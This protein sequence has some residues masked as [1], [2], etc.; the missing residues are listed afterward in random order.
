ADRDSLSARRLRPNDKRGPGPGSCDHRPERGDEGGGRRQTPHSFFSVTFTFA[1]SRPAFSA[2]RMRTVLGF[3]PGAAS[4]R[5]WTPGPLKR[6]GDSEEKEDAFP[7][8]LSP[9][10]TVASGGSA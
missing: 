6:S 2:T 7:S 10:D 4:D 5:S 8:V 1:T 9:S 3:L